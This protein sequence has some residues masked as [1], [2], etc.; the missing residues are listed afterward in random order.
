MLI[1]KNEF[2]LRFNYSCADELYDTFVQLGE[3]NS[4]S[5]NLANFHSVTETC[6]KLFPDADVSGHNKIRA[7]SIE[8]KKLDFVIIAKLSEDQNKMRVQ[9]LNC[10]ANPMDVMQIY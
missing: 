9:L 5:L 3:L 4:I 2:K 8:S 1:N 7:I 6:L 10:V